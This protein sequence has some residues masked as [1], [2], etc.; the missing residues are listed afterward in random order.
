MFVFKKYLTLNDLG[1]FSYRGEF[2]K[3]L[4]LLVLKKPIFLVALLSHGFTKNYGSKDCNF[5]NVLKKRKKGTH[6]YGVKLPV[7]HIISKT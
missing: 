7:Y 4:R 1:M 3:V 5:L 2:K 6:Q